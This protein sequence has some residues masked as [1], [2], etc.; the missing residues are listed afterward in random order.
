MAFDTR[1]EVVVGALQ[2]LVIATDRAGAAKP[3]RSPAE[4]RCGFRRAVA[5]T[6][7]CM[8]S[9]AGPHAPGFR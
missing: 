4:R 5:L 7:G 9:I 2:D 8:A 6:A 1:Q 3:G